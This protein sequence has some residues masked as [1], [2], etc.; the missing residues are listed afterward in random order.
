[1]RL[2][3]ACPHSRKRPRVDETE[4]E[5]AR[6]RKRVLDLVDGMT[7]KGMLQR[8]ALET[9][10]LAKSTYYGWRKAFR[11]GGLKALAP[12]ST[13]PK[14]VRQRRWTDADDR[15]VLEL[16]AEY[17]FM[18]K[19]RLKAMPGRRGVRLSVS[20]AGPSGTAASNAPTAPP[21]SSSG[22]DATAPSPSPP[23]RPRSPNTS[24]S[25]TTKGPTMRWIAEPRTSIL[26]TPGTC[27][28]RQ[29]EVP[30]CP[31]PL[32]HLDWF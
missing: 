8:D 4:S 17:P 24:S 20:T 32:H 28:I 13:R 30:K 6:E 11:R 15:A 1:M 25:T 14:S 3:H 2:L 7:A 5:P 19:A 21:G 12:K 26:S 10:G 16:R 23:S 31:E 18:G 9:I 29:A 22:T 27:L